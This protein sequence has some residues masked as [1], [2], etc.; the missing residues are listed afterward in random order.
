MKIRWLET[1]VA[2]VKAGSFNGAARTLL[3]SQPAVTQQLQALERELGFH[4]IERGVR[5]ARLTPDGERVYEHAA[6]VLGALRDLDDTT[7]QIALGRAGRIELGATL[8]AAEWL[9]PRLVAA[10]RAQAPDIDVSVTVHNQRQLLAAFADHTIQ[11]GVLELVPPEFLAVPLRRHTLIAVVA[12]DQVTSRRPTTLLLR[13]R[14]SEVRETVDEW[15]AASGLT[16]ESTMELASN[17]ALRESAAAGLGCAILSTDAVGFELAAG[18]VQLI[19][20]PGLPIH[21][22]WYLVY[23]ERRRLS[24][25]GASFVRFV[26]S[27]AGHVAVNS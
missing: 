6:A 12:P 21:R 25:A 5:G 18:R 27:P 20:L 8:T 10:F 24:P 14:G 23:Q 17:A 16:F 11:L 15:L 2:I 13:E 7:Q 9:V 1:F 3:L 22:M 19:D 4:L 26:S